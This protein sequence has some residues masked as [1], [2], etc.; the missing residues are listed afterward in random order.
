[1]AISPTL[2]SYLSQNNV[3]FTLVPHRH[4]GS[5]M[6]TAQAAH[7]P[8]DALAKAVGMKHDGGYVMV[9]IPSNQHVDAADFKRR[10][11]HGFELASEADLSTALPDCAV[12]AVPPVGAA[13]G[14]DVYLDDCL[15]ARE[16]IFFEAGDHEELVRMS[17]PE[18]ES[19]LQ[20]A[21]R[22]HFGH[23]I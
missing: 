5:S 11:G 14:M 7:I 1:M 8:G 20:T 23:T 2:K 15:V 19:L 22:G 18:F 9:V 3:Q 16:E 6:E 10:F 21:D 12:G 13:W 17:G 4:T